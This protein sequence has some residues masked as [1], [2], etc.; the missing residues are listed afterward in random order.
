M[1]D[2]SISIRV[3]EEIAERLEA[4]AER[5]EITRAAWCREAVLWALE[6]DEN[7]TQTNPEQPVEHHVPAAIKAVMP[8]R[9]G[10]KIIMP[11]GRTF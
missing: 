6:E 10:S 8:K 2:K 11:K 7:P 9:F 3:S 5:S 1:P 4:A